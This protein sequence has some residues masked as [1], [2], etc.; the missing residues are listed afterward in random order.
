MYKSVNYCIPFSIFWV[1]CN[2]PGGIYSKRLTGLQ[3][4]NCTFEQLENPWT[5]HSLFLQNS[6]T[7]VQWLQ[8]NGLTVQEFTCPKCNVPCNLCMRS[9]NTDGV[10]FR[11]RNRKHEYSVRISFSSSTV[12]WTKTP[13]MAVPNSVDLTIK[14]PSVDWANFIR[15]LFKQWVYDLYENVEFEGTS[16]LMRVYS[17]EDASTIAAIPMWG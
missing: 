14:K 9:K 3:L 4:E 15:D 11:C 6:Y 13:S 16:K 10:A 7:I 8:R 5:F 12:S 17:E 1:F 2:M